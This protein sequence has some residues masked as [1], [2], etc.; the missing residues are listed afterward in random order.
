MEEKILTKAGKVN[1]FIHLVDL[2][3]FGMPKVLAAFI[4]VF[5]EATVIMDCGSSLEVKRILHYLKKCNIPLSSIKYLIPTHH[6]FDHAGGMW[7]LYNELKK[8]NSEVKILTNDKTKELLNDYEAH[9]ARAKRTYGDFAGVMRPLEQEAFKIISPSQRFNPSPDDLEVIET[10]TLN[11]SEVKLAILETP[12]HT[13]DHQSPL[14]VQN[15][16]IIFLYAGEAAG[17]IYHSTKLI[18]MPTSMPIYF[19]YETFMNTLQHLKHLK[20]PKQLGLTHFGVVN[21]ADNVKFVFEDQT[22]FL[23]EFREKVKLYY[24]EKPET[25]YIYNKLIPYFAARTDIP[26]EGETK[27][28][29]GN[30]ILGVVYGMMM[31]LGFR[32]Q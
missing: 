27:L 2:H 5:D 29:L 32:K 25:E 28:A 9:L 14:F 8:H 12:G 13:P 17:T 24:A 30:I 1:D 31:D 18:T 11:G 23:A 10:F 4:G 20:T 26:G 22:S 19:N 21:G 16:Q 3:E 15:S 7:K 6:H